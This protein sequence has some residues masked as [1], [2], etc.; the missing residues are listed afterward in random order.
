MNRIFDAHCHVGSWG[1]H[2]VHGRRISPLVG[3]E[4]CNPDSLAKY[5]RGRGIERAVV[6]P[7]YTPSLEQTFA[8]NAT[9]LACAAAIPDRVVPGFW[10]DPSVNARRLLTDALALAGRR[11][12][13]VLKMSPDAWPD[14]YTADPTSWDADFVAGMALIMDYASA[15]R[16]VVQVHTGGGKSDVRSV[17]KMVRG[18]P[19]DVS[20]H[21]VHMGGRAS[22]H[23][24][25][26]PRLAD[27]LSEGLD[28]YCDTSLAHAFAVRWICSEAESVTEI[29][30]RILFASDEPWGSCEAELA[31]LV[32]ATKEDARLRDMILFSNAHSLYRPWR[33]PP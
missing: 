3:H 23:F 18:S 33:S 5:L 12:V 1:S 22:G 6:V 31:K 27:W 30:S 24:Y 14:P 17:E 20:F 25:L 16:G 7:T 10:V 21:L 2:V 13:R 11:C 4:C 15:R 32:V 28:I 29:R 9:V 26:V 8:L 19:R